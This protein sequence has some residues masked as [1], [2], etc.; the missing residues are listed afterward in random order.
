MHDDIIVATNDDEDD[1]LN[2][3]NSVEIS[4][5]ENLIKEKEED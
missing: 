4:T 2:K 5:N 3:K 1:I